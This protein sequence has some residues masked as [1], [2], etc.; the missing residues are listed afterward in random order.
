[1]PTYRSLGGSDNGDHQLGEFAHS[2]GDV[3]DEFQLR[4][5]TALPPTIE[6][7]QFRRGFWRRF[8]S[9]ENRARA[10]VVEVVVGEH[11]CGPSVEHFGYLTNYG[12]SRGLPLAG[13]C[14]GGPPAGG[15]LLGSRT[16]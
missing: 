2:N 14:L 6:K 9:V 13:A 15:A 16:G 3:A 12:Y 5:A 1:M 10:K 8:L 11:A 7:C 4:R